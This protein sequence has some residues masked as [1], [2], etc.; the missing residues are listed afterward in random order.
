MNKWYG[1]AIVAYLI[2]AAIE[3][4][5]AAVQLIRSTP[6]LDK[7]V[8]KQPSET[9]KPSF[10]QGQVWA[11]IATVSVCGAVS[12]PCRLIHRTLKE[13]HTPHDR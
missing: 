7:G 13:A 2:G 1:I 6:E 8:Q 4:V 5:G 12:W 10:D 11:A 9:V 3:G